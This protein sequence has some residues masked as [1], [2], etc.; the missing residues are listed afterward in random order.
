M[1]LYYMLF[2]L[3]LV[4]WTAKA[5]NKNANYIVTRLVVGAKDTLTNIEY[6]D[7]LGR[8]SE[9]VKKGYSANG[10][11][12][13]VSLIE[14]DGMGNE[15]RSW[16]STPFSHTGNVID[17][18]VYK[19][20]SK[21]VYADLAPFSEYE[22][23]KTSNNQVVSE[24]GPG[25]A[26][27][28]SKKA[29]T[30]EYGGVAS[31]KYPLFMLSSGNQKFSYNS[32][33]YVTSALSMVKV[34]DEDGITNS[35][36]YDLYGHLV[37]EE[38][39]DGAITF[40]LY[41]VYGNLIYVLPPAA[42]NNCLTKGKIYDIETDET[43]QKYAYFYRYD[44]KN[45]C[46]EKKLP[47]CEP[48]KMIYDTENRL[49]F[50]QDGNQR[51]SNE[52]LFVLYDSYGRPTV[53]GVCRNADKINISNTHVQSSFSTSGKYAMYDANISLDI[54]ELLK[55]NYYDSYAFLGKDSLYNYQSQDGYDR[56]IGHDGNKVSTRGLLTGCRTYVLPS[57]NTTLMTSDYHT[58]SLYY[59]N[60][61][62][63]VQCHKDNGI[64]GIDDIYYHRNP[65][66]GS[67]LLEKTV[68]N[69]SKARINTANNTIETIIK[70][71]T[72]DQDGRLDSMTYKLNDNAEFLVKHCEYDDL[73][74]VAKTTSHA[75]ALSTNYTY[76]VRE[77]LTSATN[78][79]TEQRIYY[80]TP[81]RNGQNILAYNGDI[82]A[83]EWKGYKDGEWDTESYSYDYDNQNRLSSA[84]SLSQ[85]GSQKAMSGQHD[86][87][88]EYDLM[89]N[90]TNITRKGVNCDDEEEGYRDNAVLEY[91]GNQ[92]VHVTNKGF[93]DSSSDTQIADREYSNAAEYQYDANG[94]MTRNLNKGILKIKY[95]VLNLPEY[96]YMR[97]NQYLHNIYD[98]DG[99]KLSSEIH[100]YK[101]NIT[102]PESG[103]IQGDLDTLSVK[104]NILSRNFPETTH[105]SGDFIYKTKWVDPSKPRPY[106]VDT[107]VVGNQYTA[108]LVLSRINFE[109]GYIVPNTTKIQVYDYVKDYLGN[110]RF[111]EKNDQIVETNN[112]YPFG[113]F[114]REDDNSNSQRWKFG[115]KELDRTIDQYHWGFRFYDPTVGAFTTVDP[116]CEL[117][118]DMTPYSFANNNPANYTDLF[119]L[120]TYSWNDFVK[121]WR[122]FD[123][124]KDDVELPDVYCIVNKPDDQDEILGETSDGL[125]RL[126][127]CAKF[128]QK[129][130]EKIG[131]SNLSK[132]LYEMNKYV[133]YNYSSLSKRFQLSRFHP[134]EVYKGITKG[135]NEV[136]KYT[137]YAGWASTAMTLIKIGSTGELELPD[138]WDTAIPTVLS[139]IP[140]Y[141]WAIAGGYLLLDTGVKI[142]TGKDIGE[143]ISDFAREQYGYD[144]FDFKNKTLINGTLK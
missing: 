49:I 59:N 91:D 74:R 11:K 130:N 56:D 139:W 107:Y 106:N 101:Y 57:S 80:N 131:G 17:A 134:S 68:H 13:L 93:K 90:I 95:N 79:L 58:Q 127:S 52:W 39:G 115:N 86:T 3:L 1:K 113:G 29:R 76:N 84:Y 70:R 35:K 124:N 14:Y 92:L 4:P 117:N 82:S 61:G 138:A 31:M 12:D 60:K 136:T 133:K 15:Y 22:Y 10:G 27:H 43:L 97:N 24:I 114:Y 140:G 67:V 137:K 78:A 119:G 85:I 69:R 23:D 125:G 53:R 135:L 88:Y 30:I 111:V 7:G 109:E 144:T 41:D 21:S 64:G 87:H 118:Y 73:G 8:S 36:Y 77:Q 123:V 132:P 25:Y 96:I 2:A 120:K 121:H 45:R 62:E 51:G 16:N 46:I 5:Q 50:K 103:S 99:T 32:R 112:Y 102:V 55:A 108:M 143:H 98:G 28:Q 48:I 94:N 105:Y 26:W 18:D 20:M 9:M 81:Y 129:I 116:M 47:G 6:F 63:V 66:T 33:Y 110:I 128:F 83:Y 44:G 104:Q 42:Y 75:N 100:T 126:D 142:C 122:D 37:M 54:K 34:T 38:Q 19:G 141:G 89:G 72:Y 65:Y 40:Y 71:Y